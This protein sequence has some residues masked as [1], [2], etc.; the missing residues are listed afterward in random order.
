MIDRHPGR[1]LFFLT[2]CFSKAFCFW[3]IFERAKQAYIILRYH[4]IIA[5]NEKSQSN[6]EIHRS[7]DMRSN[8]FKTK[9]VLAI[10]R[11][12]YTL[13]TSPLTHP[14]T[15][16]LRRDQNW[17]KP[18]M[19]IF[20]FHS[21]CNLFHFHWG[22]WPSAFNLKSRAVGIMFHYSIAWSPFRSLGLSLGLFSGVVGVNVVLRVLYVFV[23]V[24]FDL[25]PSSLRARSF[26]PGIHNHL[27]PQ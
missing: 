4:I 27:P 9:H 23:I 13:P 6:Q 16:R 1:D 20:V 25:F 10:S 11:L 2:L 7:N 5:S 8:Q 21:L 19:D 14:S 3:G 15:S 24:C 18:C 26:M 17:I 22:I 12:S